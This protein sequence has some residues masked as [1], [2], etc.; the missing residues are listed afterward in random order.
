MSHL[1]DLQTATINAYDQHP[2][3]NI[4]TYD[5][6][7]R[8]SRQRWLNLHEL[9][10]ESISFGNHIEWL[11]ANLRT[12]EK[13]KLESCGQDL[14]KQSNAL[15]SAALDISNGR[16]DAH[17]DFDLIMQAYE[18]APQRRRIDYSS[19]REG[20]AAVGDEGTIY[21][22]SG[23]DSTLTYATITHV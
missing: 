20:G 14:V 6:I 9:L 10:K 21:F 12:A 22:I 4:A 1:Y 16:E 8:I 5:R 11:G 18:G 15:L 19:T 2:P 3:Q 17:K 23:R 7:R 13:A